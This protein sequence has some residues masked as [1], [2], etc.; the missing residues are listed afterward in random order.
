[1][2]A[3]RRAEARRENSRRMNTEPT[4][5]LPASPPLPSSDLLGCPC[6]GAKAELHIET[7]KPIGLGYVICTSY[8]CGLQT[9]RSIIPATLWN[10]RVKPNKELTDRRGAGSVK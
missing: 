3:E 1:M 5:Q 7:G 9:R 2:I 6:C 4:I 10:R 8:E